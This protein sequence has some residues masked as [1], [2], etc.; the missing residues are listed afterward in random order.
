MAG[1]QVDVDH[2]DDQR[3]ERVEDEAG[4]R[5]REA[6]S[7][8]RWSPFFSTYLNSSTLA[9]GSADYGRKRLSVNFVFCPGWTSTRR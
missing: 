2:G 5:Q 9:N 4:Q 1:G 8:W 3:R 6:E 7:R